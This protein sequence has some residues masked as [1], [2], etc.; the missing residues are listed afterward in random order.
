MYYNTSWNEPRAELAFEFYNFISFVA[1]FIDLGMTAQKFT[2]EDIH[3][4]RMLMTV[5][6]GMGS[7]VSR[8]RIACVL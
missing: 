8:L 6:R 5:H 7:D 4:I 2:L 3:F 1:A